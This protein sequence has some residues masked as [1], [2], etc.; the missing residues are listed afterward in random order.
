MPQRFSLYHDLSVQ[1][2]LDFFADVFGVKG[3]ARTQRLERLLAFSRLGEFTRRR[4]QNLSGGMKQKLALCCALIHSPALCILDEPTT[5]VDPVS[6]NEFWKILQELVAGGVTILVS[7]PYMDETRYCGT[8]AM[9]H[10]GRVLCQGTPAQLLQTY[11]YE[12]YRVEVDSR[13]QAA[14][15]DRAGYPDFVRR[16]YPSGGELRVI[17]ERGV[18]REKVERW[19]RDAVMA[20]GA[21]QPAQPAMEDV[22]IERVG[23]E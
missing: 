11:P 14:A 10:E 3:S 2:N 17:V 21:A 13:A 23:E 18:E 5:G 16:I 20:G 15:Q 19:I 12:V 9:I 22:F 6:R 8:V 7:T 1:E 4:A